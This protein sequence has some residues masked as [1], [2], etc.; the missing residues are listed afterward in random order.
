M[1]FLPGVV[2]EEPVVVKNR[3]ILNV[4]DL[5]PSVRVDRVSKK[6][7]ENVFRSLLRKALMV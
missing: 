1:G 3:I 7:F 5:A 2:T 6:K 4:E